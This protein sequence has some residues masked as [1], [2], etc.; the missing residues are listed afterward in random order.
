MINPV[1]RLLYRSISENLLTRI[2]DGTYPNGFPLPSEDDLSAAFKVSRVT[3]RKA[4]Q[5]L[6]N[7]GVLKSVQGSGTKVVYRSGALSGEMDA[8]ALVARAQDPFFAA[9]YTAFEQRAEENNTLVIFKQDVPGDAL[10]TGTLFHRLVQK[11]IRNVVVWPRTPQISEPTLRRM[12]AAGVNLVIFDQPFPTAAA[13]VVCLDNA[14]A[15]MT[16]VQWLNHRKIKTIHLLSFGDLRL[17]SIVAREKAFQKLTVGRGRVV[18]LNR[19]GNL[20]KQI[21]DWHY[22][23]PNPLQAAN[24]IICVNGEVGLAAARVASAPNGFH[25]TLASLDHFPGME[26]YNM[27]IYAQPVAELAEAAFRSLLS[28]NHLAR[29]WVPRTIR[30]RGRLILFNLE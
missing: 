17:P 26:D 11:G 18:S 9:F 23:L 27:A 29:S 19:M 16:L 14:H 4:L 30:R 21:V 2:M 10:V 8:I 20:E 25:P 22:G 7:Q 12:R 5:V 3:L 6:K 28:Q 15:V 1:P 24:G 13:D